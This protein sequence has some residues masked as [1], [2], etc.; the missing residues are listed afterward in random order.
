MGRATVEEERGGLVSSFRKVQRALGGVGAGVNKSFTFTS[1]ATIRPP[2][3]ATSVG[4]T[5][6]SAPTFAR[7]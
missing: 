1:I 7:P 4:P 5:A 2:K 3:A 6:A